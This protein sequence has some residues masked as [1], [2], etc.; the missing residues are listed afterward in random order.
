MRAVEAVLRLCVVIGPVGGPPW[1]EPG[2]GHAASGAVLLVA[3]GMSLFTPLALADGRPSRGEARDTS[4][5]FSVAAALRSHPRPAGAPDGVVAWSTRARARQAPDA[6][7]VF[8]HG[9]NGCV[10]HI[11]APGSV[12]CAAGESSRSEPGW[13]L[14]AAH[15][16][17]GTDSLFILPQLAWKKR[18]GNPGRFREREAWDAMLEA[19]R[20]ALPAA[21]RPASLRRVVLVAHSA[22]FETALAILGYEPRVTDVILLDA[23]Y[24]GADRFAE[25]VTAAPNRRLVSVHRGQGGPDRHTRTTARIVRHKRGAGAVVH[26]SADPLP[27]LRA[28]L[29]VVRTHV[30]HRDL[31]KEML[32]SLLHALGDVSS[33]R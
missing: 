4:R 21:E 19:A 22:G 2:M 29:T 20:S 7:V 23:M 30:A 24:D 25:W 8:L 31:P 3:F 13:D 33:A 5:E 32:A 17:A 14:I 12:A 15:A 18:S 10:R 16:R 9:W 6:A 26:V 27:S 11:A 1:Y 28:P